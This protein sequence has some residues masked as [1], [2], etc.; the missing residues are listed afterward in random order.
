MLEQSLVEG[1]VRAR[2]GTEPP[3]WAEAWSW[4]VGAHRAAPT[5]LLLAK[6]TWLCIVGEGSCSCG[7]R[8]TVTPVQMWGWAWE[9]VTG[10]GPGCFLTSH[11]VYVQTTFMELE[12]C[13]TDAGLDSAFST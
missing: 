6:G 4:E 12:V 1:G 8:R 9:S 13:I 11:S 5:C 7:Q 2:G 3:V 10:P